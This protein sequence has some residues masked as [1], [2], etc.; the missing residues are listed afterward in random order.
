ML[1]LIVLF[2]IGFIVGAQ[3]DRRKFYLTAALMCFVFLCFCF[4]WQYEKMWP[5][6]LQSAFVAQTGKWLVTMVVGLLIGG[7]LLGN[8]LS[9]KN[10]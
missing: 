6:L 10:P 7:I 4:L 2:L 3:R 8:V 1:V 5:G 9:R